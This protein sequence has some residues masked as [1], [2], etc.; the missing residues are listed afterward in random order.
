MRQREHG[1]PFKALPRVLFPVLGS[2]NRCACYLITPRA[3]PSWLRRQLV[4]HKTEKA[5]SFI[6][7][8]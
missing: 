6:G 8:N 7:Q 5:C 3:L 2:L 4:P 1:H